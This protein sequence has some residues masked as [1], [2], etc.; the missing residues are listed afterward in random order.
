MLLIE[1]FEEKFM[2]ILKQ[3]KALQQKGNKK[4]KFSE[5]ICDFLVNFGVSIF[6]KMKNRKLFLLFSIFF[7]EYKKS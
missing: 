6:K 2:E 1:K 4:A 7:L 5:T 3:F